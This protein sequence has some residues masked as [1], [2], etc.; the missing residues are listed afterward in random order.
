MREKVK[1]N[2][3]IFMIR[4]KILKKKN[5][6]NENRWKECVWFYF[7]NKQNSDDKLSKGVY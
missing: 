2:K 3:Q 6:E 4:N 5:I 1:E 7:T